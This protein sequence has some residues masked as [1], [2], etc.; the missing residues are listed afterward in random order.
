MI[1]LKAI[2]GIKSKE[3][4]NKKQIKLQIKNKNMATQKAAEVP[5]KEVTLN[6]KV[7]ATSVTQ[8]V[9]EVLGTPEKTLYYLIVETAKGKEII[10]V[11]EK[12]MT[13]I[14]NLTK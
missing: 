13:K 3:I 11:G 8:T 10:N 5:A 14:T 1:S 2:K 12:T 6:A 4:P 7:S 9:N